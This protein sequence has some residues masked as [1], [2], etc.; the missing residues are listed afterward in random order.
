MSVELRGRTHL[1]IPGT[2]KC[3]AC[4]QSIAHLSGNPNKSITYQQQEYQQQ[5]PH[6]MAYC[7][8]DAMRCDA[9]T[10]K[11]TFEWAQDVYT[12]DRR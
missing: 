2:G 7:A 8:F 11:T 4:P 10:S 1:K 9:I 5:N 3:G 12:D 6:S